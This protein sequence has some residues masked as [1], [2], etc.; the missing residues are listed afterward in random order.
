MKNILSSV[1][2]ASLLLTNASASEL[3]E[4]LNLDIEDLAK[5]KVANVFAT[6]KVE[7]KIT[8]APANVSLITSE[9]IRNKHY[10]TLVEAISDQSGFYTSND[11][12]YSYLGVRGFS[13]PGDYNTK[14]LTLIDGH[15]VNENIY[16]SSSVGSNTLVDMN[17]V[18]HIE[19]IRGPGSALYGSSALFA[20]I[21]IVMKSSQDFKHG[22]ASFMVGNYG[23]DQERVTFSH[24][25]E[26]SAQLLL[27]ATRTHSDGDDNL[28]FKEFDDPSTNNGRAENIDSTDGQK[29]FLKSKIDN[30]SIEAIYT[31][32]KKDIPTAPWST[33][34]NIADTDLDEHSYININH[35]AN[36]SN[37]VSIDSS[38]SYNYYKYTGDYYY[39]DGGVTL[40]K[41]EA[42]GQWLDGTLDLNYKQSEDLNW[43]IG[44]YAMD[45]IEAKQ[46]YE[47]DN[48]TYLDDDHPDNNY[49]VYVQSIY[50]ATQKISFTLGARYDYYETIGGHITPK[51]SAI[52]SFSPV[53]SLKFIYGEA[54]RAPNPYELYYSDGDFTMKGNT[55]LK[56]ENIKN[57]EVVFEHYF[58]SKHSL[59]INGFYYEIENLIQQATDS[60]GLLYFDNLDKAKSQGVEISYNYTF[61]N[62]VDSSLNYT[63]QYA[64]D[65]ET[66]KWLVNSPKQLANASV[67]VPFLNKYNAIILLKYVGEK[68]NPNGEILND[69]TL[70]NL[71]F[72]A[73]DVIKGL[74]LSAN[75]DNLFDTTYSSSP[76][77]EHIQ[78]EIIQNGISFNI[79]A[80]YKF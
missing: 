11:R 45:S 58:A 53:S 48:V 47:Y 38:L 66:D 70:A 39:E 69:Y 65:G 43:L 18:D 7:Q 12:D 3:D 29:F 22:E 44:V 10:R 16:S 52:Y 57:Y 36:L 24:I 32:R 56:E 76:G 9:E 33:I 59:I 30:F 50:R 46:T 27:S 20:V 26:N 63:Y 73:Y 2:V 64:V 51:L 5:I 75:I 19:I 78:K 8:D 28:Y 60:N 15:R 35:H 1:A 31:K 42:E 68:K 37:N 23:I 14:I 80:V 49:A 72:N 41:D 62:G 6:S 54:F 74:D 17:M 25:F 13:T 21:N 71:D 40:S 4:L 55:D 61:K 34:F 77:G 79:Q 67:T